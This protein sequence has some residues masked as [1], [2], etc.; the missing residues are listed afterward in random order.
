MQQPRSASLIA[1]SEPRPPLSN[2][3]EFL[4]SA[5]LGD[6]LVAEARETINHHKMP[7][8]LIRVTNQDGTLIALVTGRAYR[9]RIPFDV[10]NLM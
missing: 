6:H 9:K 5:R 1:V 4:V 8:S 3:I 7:Q 2:N 10:D